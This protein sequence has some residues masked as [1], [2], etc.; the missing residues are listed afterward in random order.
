MFLLLY[1]LIKYINI[2]AEVLFSIPKSSLQQNLLSY[3]FPIDQ[4]PEL[5]LD[6]INPPVAASDETT[7]LALAQGIQQDLIVS[8]ILSGGS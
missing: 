6:Q 3:R 5:T 8:A 7:Q 4:F 1:L 2:L